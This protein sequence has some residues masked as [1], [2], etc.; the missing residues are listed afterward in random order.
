MANPQLDQR[1]RDV[2]RALIQLHINTG[3]P[4]GSE[5]LAREFHSSVSSA[6]LRNVMAELEKKGY[7]THPHTSAGRIP[8]D[9]GYRFYV[10]SLMSASP[11]SS[12]AISAIDSGIR[13]ADNPREAL[14][15][16]SHMLSSHS[17]NVGFVLVPDVAR[18]TLLHIDLVRLTHPRVLVVMVS[19]AGLVTNKV[20]EI[21]EELSGDDLQACANYLNAHFTGLALPAV[22]TRLLELMQE[23]K[24]LY[25]TLLKRVL[26][27]AGRAFTDD[28]GDGEVVI[29]GTSNI[30][31]ADFED[32]DRLRALFKAFEQKGRL[33]KILNGCLAEGGVR[34]TI[35]QENPDPDMRRTAVVTASFPLEGA[36]AFGLGVVGS[37]R[38]EYAKVVA[39][40]DHVARALNDAL[41]E[42]RA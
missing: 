4:V 9:E 25:D 41:K 14:E 33:V 15:L 6:T 21:D 20:I 32:I 39:L 38:M 26:A 16:A 19:R 34:I 24:A 5:S 31:Q 29:D 11:L 17:G 35:G 37:T 28:A 12:R 13:Q 10:D 2:L 8:T 23:E 40:V 42:L 30:L 7:L 22:R 18:S 36:P 1:S 3:Q 27:V